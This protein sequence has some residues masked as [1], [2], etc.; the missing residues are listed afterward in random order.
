MRKEAGER[1]KEGKTYPVRL[2]S[3]LVSLLDASFLCVTKIL[4]QKSPRSFCK[5]V[6]FQILLANGNFFQVYQGT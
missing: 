5:Q 1:G 4:K 3:F 6:V 2:T